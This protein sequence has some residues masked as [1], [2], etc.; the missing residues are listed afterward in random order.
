MTK[1]TGGRNHTHIAGLLR[2]HGHHQVIPIH[3][4]RAHSWDKNRPG[5]NGYYLC[6]K[7]QSHLAAEDG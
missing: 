2:R 4:C 1:I 3:D 7:M 5:G 6:R